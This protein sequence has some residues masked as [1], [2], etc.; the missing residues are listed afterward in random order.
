MQTLPDYL[1]EGL[2]IV[3]VGLN[4]SA[5]SARE[6]HYF[7]NPRN[8]FWTAFNRSG[9]VGVELSAE[10]DYTLPEHGIGLTDVVKR[11]T[12]QGSELR[13]KDFR[14]WAPVLM[15][16]LYRFQP[17]IVCFHGVT[18]YNQYLKH[19]EGIVEKSQLGR[20][21]RTI[22]S[23]GVFVVPSPSPANARY[24]VDDLADWYRKLGSLK[25]ELTAN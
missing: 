19:G 1:N 14:E 4:P 11:P 12:A 3:L 2:D 25:H 5:Y 17:G 16:K 7:A 20:Q 18:A 24:S 10:L 9:L 15:Q 8:R 23:S 13:S 6:G 21:E 22:G